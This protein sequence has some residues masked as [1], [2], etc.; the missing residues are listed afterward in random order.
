MSV[1]RIPFP[2]AICGND[3]RP[4]LNCSA[5]FLASGPMPRIMIGIQTLS[6]HTAQPV[7]IFVCTSH[8]MNCLNGDR[9]GKEIRRWEFARAAG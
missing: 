2:G 6:R 7:K 1:T 9:Y 8:T 3:R 4:T 5:V